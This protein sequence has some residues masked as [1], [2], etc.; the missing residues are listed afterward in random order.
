MT[1][2]IQ[3]KK[4]M[5]CEKMKRRTYEINICKMNMHAK[6]VNIISLFPLTNMKIRIIICA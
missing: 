2:A 1:A 4:A 5:H 3:P 6:I